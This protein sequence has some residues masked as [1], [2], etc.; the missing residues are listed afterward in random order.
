MKQR[1]KVLESFLL[2][3]FC[4]L[5]LS[6]WPLWVQTFGEITGTVTDA[7]G[8]VVVGASIT[9]TNVSTNQIRRLET[10]RTGNYTV[11]FLAPTSRRRRPRA[12]R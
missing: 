4:L 5:A 7:T 1:K 9:V 12:R 3:L 2:A 8:A 10:N 6:A 11:P